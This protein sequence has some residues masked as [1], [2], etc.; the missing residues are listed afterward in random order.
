[1]TKRVLN[2]SYGRYDTPFDWSVV[3]FNFYEKA[4][5]TRVL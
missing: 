2:L 1:M 5:W 4:K 3:V